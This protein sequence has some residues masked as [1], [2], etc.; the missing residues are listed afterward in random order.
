MD[1]I[2]QTMAGR[3]KAEEEEELP[4]SQTVVSSIGLLWK[5]AEPHRPPWG[6]VEQAN[7]AVSYKQTKWPKQC[8]H[9]AQLPNFST[10]RFCFSFAPN[11]KPHL[12]FL[13]YPHSPLFCL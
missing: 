6:V 13:S 11:F 8:K 1:R 12:V 10:F 4:L 2:N 5:A 9:R 3:R 7:C